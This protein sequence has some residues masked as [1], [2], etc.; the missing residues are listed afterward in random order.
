MGIGEDEARGLREM[1]ISA[2]TERAVMNEKGKVKIDGAPPE[3]EDIVVPA[4]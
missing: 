2:S 1:G 4:H 3:D